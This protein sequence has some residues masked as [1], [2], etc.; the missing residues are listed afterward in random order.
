MT[1]DE[2]TAQIKRHKVLHI[3]NIV[4]RKEMFVNVDFENFDFSDL[5]LYNCVF[6]GCKFRGNKCRETSFFDS[7]FINCRVL[8]K[9]FQQFLLEDECHVMQLSNSPGY[10]KWNG[11]FMPAAVAPS[12]SPPITDDDDS[13]EY[14]FVAPESPH[15]EN[16]QSP[17]RKA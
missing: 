12:T 7:V 4:I 6:Y 8:S 3:D 1:L 15:W 9:S 11:F 2:L 16:M 5:E 13:S 14:E 10:H 17:K